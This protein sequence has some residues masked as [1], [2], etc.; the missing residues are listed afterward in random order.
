MIDIRHEIERATIHFRDEAKRRGMV[1]ISR[2]FIVLDH[3]GGWRFV[4]TPYWEIRFH[5]GPTER[6]IMVPKIRMADPIDLDDIPRTIR[7]AE[8][9]ATTVLAPDNPCGGCKACCRIKEA[10]IP[11]FLNKGAHQTCPHMDSCVNG[12]CIHPVRP[13]PCRDY[14]CDWLASQSRNDRMPIHLRPD[15]CGVIFETKGEVVETFLD[16]MWSCDPLQQQNVRDH[17]ISLQKFGLKVI[18]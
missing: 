14:A 7:L 2:L 10:I 6:R 9:Y 18:E 8:R 1:P 12:C 13:S 4:I 3:G 16:R 15:Q 5:L 11:D 17:I